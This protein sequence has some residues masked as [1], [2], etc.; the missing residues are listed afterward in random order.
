VITSA[1]RPGLVEL[2]VALKEMAAPAG[3]RMQLKVVPWDVYVGQYDK[4]HVFTM[5]PWNGRATIDESL[6]PF[7]HSKGSYNAEFNY[8]NKEIDALLEAGR[9]EEDFAKRKEI[10]GKVQTILTDDGPEMIPY[11]RPYLMA[12]H[13]RVQNYQVHPLRYVDV[14][15]TWLS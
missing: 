10:Y 1:E 8:T 4:K 12:I 6:Y 3:F 5:Q 11:H 2:A 7:Y 13:K 15:S 9:A 14:R